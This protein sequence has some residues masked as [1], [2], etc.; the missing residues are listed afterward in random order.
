MSTTEPQDLSYIERRILKAF[1]D[2]SGGDLESCALNLW[3]AIDDTAKRRRDGG[4]GSR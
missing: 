3:P 2:Y 1:T 4:V